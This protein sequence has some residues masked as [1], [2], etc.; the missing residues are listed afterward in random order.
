MKFLNKNGI[1]NIYNEDITFCAYFN[2]NYKILK[3][4]LKE[5]YHVSDEIF[6]FF[7]RE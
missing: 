6:N 2:K 7:N 1:K 4:L 3:Y 5:G